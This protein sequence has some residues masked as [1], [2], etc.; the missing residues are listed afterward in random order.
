MSITAASAENTMNYLKENKNKEQ[1]QE[2]SHEKYDV[3]NTAENKMN[4]GD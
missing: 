3:K 1:K 2:L 4:D